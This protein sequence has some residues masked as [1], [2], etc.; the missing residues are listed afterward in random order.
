M[1]RSTTAG[2]RSAEVRGDVVIGTGSR[3]GPHGATENVRT[4]DF[5]NVVLST[6]FNF[7]HAEGA[8]ARNIVQCSRQCPPSIRFVHQRLELGEFRTALGSN[9]QE[10]LLLS[11]HIPA[12]S[13]G[14]TPCRHGI[15]CV[16]PSPCSAGR[17]GRTD[18]VHRPGPRLSRCAPQS[19]PGQASPRV[20]RAVNS[21]VR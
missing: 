7:S 12:L 16:G 17:S 2:V 8:H 19:H 21:L 18:E 15:P 1:P 11:T 4:H 14:L 10:M 6:G 13:V 20:L 3:N 9:K 5:R